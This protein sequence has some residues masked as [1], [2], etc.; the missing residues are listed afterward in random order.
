MEA[1]PQPHARD[2]GL[3]AQFSFE[4]VKRHE[5][6]RLSPTLCNRIAGTAVRR[7]PARAGA[8]SDDRGR[9]EPS[10]QAGHRDALERNTHAATKHARSAIAS[11]VCSGDT[12][13]S[14]GST[15]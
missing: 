7:G 2:S 9:P 3:G 10:A 14:R 15:W 4:E 11:T 6:R 12:E 1:T 8:A 13:L 5:R